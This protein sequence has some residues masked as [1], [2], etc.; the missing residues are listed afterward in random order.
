[1]SKKWIYAGLGAAFLLG[2]A[3]LT[4]PYYAVKQFRSAAEAGDVK[5]LESAVDFPAVRR[6]LKSQ[7]TLALN[8][9]MG[10]ESHRAGNPFAKLGRA[11]APALVDRLVDRVVTPKGMAN[12]AK[13]GG[14][15]EKVG[16][17]TE[18]QPLQVSYG[19]SGLNRFHLKLNQS[20]SAKN[21]ATLYFER[22]GVFGWKVKQVELPLGALE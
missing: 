20:A 22:E 18:T 5:A 7:M 4:S 15:G 12:L 11:V 8:Q 2:A 14:V 6:S 16:A 21:A 17:A 3:A 9:Q 1:M 19:Y 10:G 13:N